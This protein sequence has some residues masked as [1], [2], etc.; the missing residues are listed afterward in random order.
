MKKPSCQGRLLRD[1]RWPSASAA[2]FVWPKNSVIQI[3][4]ADHL[5]F[6]LFIYAKYT[7]KI[8]EKSIESCNAVILSLLLVLVLL[9]LEISLVEHF[10]YMLY[11]FFGPHV[12]HAQSCDEIEVFDA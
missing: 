10:G 12:E 1:V 6:A 5:R 2:L 9:V 7:T 11:L 4:R 3:C 8:E